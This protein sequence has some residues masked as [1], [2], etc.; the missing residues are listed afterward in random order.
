[1]VLA[2]WAYILK[3]LFE[4]SKENGRAKASSMR[5]QML[6]QRCGV[7]DIALVYIL[8]TLLWERGSMNYN[9][10]ATADAKTKKAMK[11]SITNC[12]IHICVAL[13]RGIIILRAI[14]F[15]AFPYAFSAHLLCL[16]S[17]IKKESCFRLRMC[18]PV[19]WMPVKEMKKRSASFIIRGSGLHEGV[20]RFCGS[21]MSEGS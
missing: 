17:H 4:R 5:K 19:W 14:G 18:R 3:Y 11:R 12:F 6:G 7:S 15:I 1:M 21:E 20:K 8:A 10:A 13:L 9:E 16:Y 2:R